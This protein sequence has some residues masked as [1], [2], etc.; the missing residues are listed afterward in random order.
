MTDILPQIVALRLKDKDP[1]FIL[2]D[3]RPADERKIAHIQGDIHIPAE[4]FDPARF[5]GKDIVLYC[6]TGVR[7]GVLAEEWQE[8]G[9][10]NVK[11]MAGGLHAWAD[12][13]DAS[14]PKYEH[15]H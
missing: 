2:V 6:R 14:L 13:V 5:N 11:N 1:N 8:K 7:S 12:K 15:Q 4:K 9:F 3:I 10:P